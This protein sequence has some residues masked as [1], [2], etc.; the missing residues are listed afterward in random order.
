[1]PVTNFTELI[2]GTGIVN[3]AM[4]PYVGILGVFTYPLIFC[5][6]IGYV[7]MKQQS[8]IAAAV[9][10]LML[11]VAFDALVLGAGIFV[12]VLHIFVTIAVGSLFLVFF[13]RLRGVPQ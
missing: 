7:Y 2:N 4:Q 12:L 6:I 3:Y 9:A 10:T 1:M 13:S 11:F 8:V 5:G